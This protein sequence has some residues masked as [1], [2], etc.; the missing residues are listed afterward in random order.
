M[1]L[2]RSTSSILLAVC[3]ACGTV[4]LDPP[5]SDEGSGATTEA[6]DSSTGAGG[7]ASATSTTGQPPATSGTSHE[8]TATTGGSDGS[9]EDTGVVFLVEPDGGS[10]IQGGGAPEGFQVRCSWCDLIAQDCP[11]DEKCMPWAND[12]GT[13]WNA[14]R[15]SPIAEDPAA[16]GEPCTVEGS[17]VSGID[18]CEQGAMCFAV[19][20]R[21][22]QG[23][24]AALCTSD[25]GFTSCA[26]DE[27]C[28]DYDDFFPSV[29]L[30]RCD[31]TDPTSCARGETC[32]EIYGDLMCVPDFS[33]PQGLPCGADEQYCAPDQA[34][35]PADELASCADPECC[36]PWCDLSAADPD[37]PCGAVPGQVCRPYLTTPPA[38]F[39]HVGVC[40]LPL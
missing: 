9:T 11:D 34:C 1:T 4:D 30:P 27:V 25:P 31:P 3:A 37:L 18:T 40:G 2:L 5:A 20:P 32:R 14:T 29:C 16:V 33:L 23:T 6:A 24:C 12:G 10:C 38:G 7:S 39:E 36:T 35:L 17:G 21:T 8:L 15:C 22:L 19:D 13:L 28:A 26:D